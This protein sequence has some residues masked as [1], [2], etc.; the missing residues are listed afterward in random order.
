MADLSDDEARALSAKM[1][2]LEL[3]AKHLRE[4]IESRPFQQ[5][6]R[7]KGTTPAQV[8]AEIEAKM[9]PEELRQWLDERRTLEAEYKAA[10][11]PPDHGEA[12]PRNPRRA[13]RRLV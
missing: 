4:S 5:M 7:D 9:S 2:G 8:L 3:R 13:Q 6:C 12:E 11:S 1:K 10:G